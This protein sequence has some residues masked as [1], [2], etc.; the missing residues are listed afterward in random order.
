MNRSLGEVYG[1]TRLALHGAGH[2]W[3]IAEEGARAARWLCAQ[4]LDGVGAAAQTLEGKAGPDCAVTIGLGIADRP[5]Q[6][7][8]SRLEFDRVSGP[9]FLVPFVAMASDSLSKPIV[10]SASFGTAL[11]SW[12]GVE[13]SGSFPSRSSVILEPGATLPKPGSKTTRVT[14]RPEDW[15]R[16]ETFAKQTYAPATDESR[17]RGAGSAQTDAD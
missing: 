11:V 2:S 10:L 8:D 4:G 3:G 6:L 15:H 9:L 12:D 14:P 7:H 1:M 16:L 5:E 17:R 13:I